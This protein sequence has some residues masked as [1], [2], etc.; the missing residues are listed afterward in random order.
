MDQCIYYISLV[1]DLAAG[2]NAWGISA[3]GSSI[4]WNKSTIFI[5]A[6]IPICT[7]QFST[8]RPS[9]FDSFSGTTN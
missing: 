2:T 6:A 7:A 4:S 8:S 9:W 1:A 3:N 5:V